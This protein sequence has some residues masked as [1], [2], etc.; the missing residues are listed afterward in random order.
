[1]DPQDSRSISPWVWGFRPG[2]HV[3][4]VDGTFV[5]RA[6][7]VLSHEQAQEHL[8]RSG[9]PTCRPAR[10]T[11]WVLMEVFGRPV[12]VQFDSRQPSQFSPCGVM[13]LAHNRTVEQDQGKTLVS[14]LLQRILDD[15][16]GGKRL[17][18]L[19]QV[20]PLDSDSLVCQPVKIRGEPD[21]RRVNLRAAYSRGAAHRGLEYFDF[22]HD[23][24]S[25]RISS[26]DDSIVKKFR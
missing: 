23:L 17:G 5:G 15:W 26:I 10:E 22:L 19:R 24:F 12:P 7:E 13:A 8:R 2:D 25:F 14:V 6:G 18:L 3:R 1:M 4:I 9:Q 11:V 16:A 20:V 21:E